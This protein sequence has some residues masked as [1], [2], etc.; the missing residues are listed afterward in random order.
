MEISECMKNNITFNDFI[1]PLKETQYY[2]MFSMKTYFQT[3]ILIFQ[4]LSS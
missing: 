1:V 2:L 4:E 3:K